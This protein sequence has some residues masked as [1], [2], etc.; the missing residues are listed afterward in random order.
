L[1]IEG[2]DS[3]MK[4]LEENIKKFCKV[5]ALNAF[6]SP[7][8]KYSL[9]QILPQFN[10]PINL[11]LLSVDIDGDEYYIFESLE[12]Y[13]PKLIILEY[14]PTIPPHIEL[15]QSVG[16]YMGCSAL[17]LI[18]LGKKKQYRAVHITT[19]NIFFLTDE[20]F[21]KGEFIEIDLVKDFK[22]D[23][24][25]SVITSYDGISYLSDRLPYLPE[26]APKQTPNIFRLI[27]N[28]FKRSDKQTNKI[29]SFNSKAELIPVELF[30]K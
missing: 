27:K 24:L 6:V 16:E 25:V 23:F 14:N 10:V 19:T 28:L 2:N 30:K 18:K 1:L 17:A 22:Y 12:L 9:D 3:K 8:G 11:D 21:E 26:I 29:P 5:K 13:R 4:E 15:V 7:K 20:I